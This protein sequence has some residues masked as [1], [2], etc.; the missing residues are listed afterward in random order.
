V[1]I[2][3]V[4]YYIEYHS[5]LPKYWEIANPTTGDFT[6]SIW[7]STNSTTGTGTHFYDNPALIGGDS[8]GVQHDWGIV[9]ANGRVGVGAVSG[10]TV[11]TTHQYN[12]NKWHC[13]TVTRVQT[14][15]VFKIYIDGVFQIQMTEAPG[16]ILTDS[17]T[18]RLGADPNN[19][20]PYDG[21]IGEFDFWQLALSDQ[22]ISNNFTV[23]RVYYGV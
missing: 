11:F 7:F 1:G 12:D 9:I 6:A 23:Q 22:D 16:A 18:I 14:T 20:Q 5:N 17:D 2:L 19:G 13:A 21:L 15:G 10:Q 3:G 4:L 8:S